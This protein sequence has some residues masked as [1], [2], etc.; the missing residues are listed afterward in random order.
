MTM[1]T[2]TPQKVNSPKLKTYHANGPQTG[3]NISRQTLFWLLL[4]NLAV[5]SPLFDKTTP[6][7]P[8]DLC[9]LP[10][11]ADWYL[12]RQS[13]KTTALF[14]HQPCRWRGNYASISIG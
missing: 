12:C 13:R 2:S 14:S 10:S 7:A 6:W 8:W 4:T 3:D 1:Q 11:M 9:D 5:L